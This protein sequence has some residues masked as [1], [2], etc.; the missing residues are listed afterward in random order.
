VGLLG[1]PALAAFPEA[2]WRK[3]WSIKPAGQVWRDLVFKQWWTDE[4]VTTG[5]DGA[6]SVRGFHGTYTVAVNGVSQ[7]AQLGPEGATLV[8]RV[9]D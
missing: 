9:A 3:D 1:R 6:A 8:V 7:E 2:L 4:A 5:A